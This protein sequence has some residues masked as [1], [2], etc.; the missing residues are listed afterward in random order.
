MRGF[1]SIGGAAVWWIVD[2]LYGDRIFAMIKPSLP[3]WL[4]TPPL[5]QFG[6]FVFTWGVPAFF[7]GL[8]LFLL[9]RRN[10]PSQQTRKPILVA[11]SDP[12]P[13]RIRLLEFRDAAIVSGW[14]VHGNTSLDGPDLLEGLRQAAL[15]GVVRL[16]G[17]PY[18]NEFES[19][20]RTEPLSEIP[21]DHWKEFRFDWHSVIA[22][23][24]NFETMTDNARLSSVRRH[25][26]GAYCDI[27][28][29]RESAIRWLE[30]GA[31]AFRGFV[32]R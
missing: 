15:D 11:K 26:K 1:F 13:E 4:T 32:K 17:R 5:E 8:G 14:N 31:S 6:S 9:W 16:W 28:V 19:L 3:D 24:D 7:F 12:E 10:E 23:A 18:R 22:A 20:N 29:E 2:R 30:K 21:R 27:Y 25:Q